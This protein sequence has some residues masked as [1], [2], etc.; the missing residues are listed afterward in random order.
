MN[1]QKFMML[2]LRMDTEEQKNEVEPWHYYHLCFNH[3][4]SMEGL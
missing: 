1:F 3:A 4:I 2:D